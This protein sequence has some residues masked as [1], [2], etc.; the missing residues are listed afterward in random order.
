MIE[1]VKKMEMS[2]KISVSILALY[3]VSFIVTMYLLTI[4]INVL[5]VFSQL[6]YLAVIVVSGYFTKA[7]FE[8][9]AKI[10]S[11]YPEDTYDLKDQ[12]LG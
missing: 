2:K 10:L 7:G 1:N 5:P 8:N 4:G 11:P 6:Q 9:R 3:F 12:I